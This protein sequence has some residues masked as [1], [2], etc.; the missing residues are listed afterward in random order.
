M[1]KP[2][3]VFIDAYY[4]RY[5]FSLANEVIIRDSALNCLY[6]GA[7]LDQLAFILLVSAPGALTA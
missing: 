4:I 7:I 6:V 5:F 1:P 3:R 2:K